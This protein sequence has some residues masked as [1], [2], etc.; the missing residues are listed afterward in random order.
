MI[1]TIEQLKRLAE[2]DD[3]YSKREV[4]DIQDTWNALRPVF[5]ALKP[6][7]ELWESGAFTDKGN[8]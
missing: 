6:I 5:N 4:Q 8:N 2:A 7:V 1:L 3:G